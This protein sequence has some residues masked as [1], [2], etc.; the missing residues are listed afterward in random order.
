VS[1]AFWGRPFILDGAQTARLMGLAAAEDGPAFGRGWWR[2]WRRMVQDCSMSLLVMDLVVDW[3]D[4]SWPVSFPEPLTG[5][6]LCSARGRER[7]RDRTRGTAAGADA[8]RGPALD[9]TPKPLVLSLFLRQAFVEEL[10]CKVSLVHRLHPTWQRASSSWPAAC[11]TS[12]GGPGH[13][14]LMHVL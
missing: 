5:R 14:L 13:H 1:L 4:W 12:L 11:P 2:T 6:Q 10:E 3:T 8:P 9:L 7:W